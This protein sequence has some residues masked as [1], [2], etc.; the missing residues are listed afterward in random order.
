MVRTATGGKAKLEAPPDFPLLARE[1][2]L[3]GSLDSL[4]TSWALEVEVKVEMEGEKPQH[5]LASIFAN[6][7]QVSSPSSPTTPTTP[8]TPYPIEGCGCDDDLPL[9]PPSQGC[10]VLPPYTIQPDKLGPGDVWDSHCHLDFLARKLSREGIRR[11]ECLEVL[12]GLD[13][14]QQLGD[15]FGGCVANFCDPRDWAQG[16]LQ[17]E[18][19][20][21]MRS[22]R[23]QERVYPPVPGC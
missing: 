11:G 23:K 13:G 5:T 10:K 21:V 8:P 20:P 22:C 14:E 6:S 9:F 17:Q 12:L 3:T 7:L 2:R 4:P 19:S 18:V 16:R 1:R 15:K